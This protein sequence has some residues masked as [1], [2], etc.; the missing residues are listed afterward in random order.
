MESLSD[1]QREAIYL[2]YTNDFSYEEIAEILNIDVASSRTLIYRSIKKIR[3]LLGR[4]A[5]VFLLFVKS[6]H[7]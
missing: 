7:Q 4:N 6:I 1:R 5:I 3:E 2:K